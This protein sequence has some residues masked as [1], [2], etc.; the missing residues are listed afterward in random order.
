MRRDEKLL[1][2]VEAEQAP[3][4]ALE[5]VG[6]LAAR[7]P[8]TVVILQVI[9]LNIVAPEGRIYGELAAEAKQRLEHLARAYLG[10][11]EHTL[12]RVRRGNR[13]QQVLAEARTQEA[14]MI[15]LTDGAPSFP[16][17][18]AAAFKPWSGPL[19]SSF[20]RKMMRTAPCS[21]IV[22]PTEGSF[23]QTEP[24]GRHV[25]GLSLGA[26]VFKIGM[27]MKSVTD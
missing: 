20:V 27:T 5:F 1:L 15:V 24:G 9:H 10:G 21:V 7:Q 22:V 4:A 13:A 6:G 8:L 19:V 12:V 17:R 23:R 11:C 25:R 14:G 26:G 2:V 16:E 3:W 18:L